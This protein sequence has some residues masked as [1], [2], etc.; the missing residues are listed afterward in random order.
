MLGLLKEEKGKKAKS[1]KNVC[2]STFKVGTHWKLWCPSLNCI[3]PPAARRATSHP[4]RPNALLSDNLFDYANKYIHC[5]A[6]KKDSMKTTTHQAKIWLGECVHI[7]K[8]FAWKCKN[9]NIL[10][11]L[12]LFLH[13]SKVIVL[14]ITMN[15][16]NE[17]INEKLV[18]IP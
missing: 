12:L 1:N 8:T 5:E 7:K 17:W 10:H 3:M 15:K 11:S 14:F 18:F 6:P 4:A 2:P 16:S 13:Y 9:M